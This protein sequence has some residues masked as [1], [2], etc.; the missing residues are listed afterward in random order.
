MFGKLGG[1][2]ED[3]DEDYKCSFLL[4][5]LGHLLNSIA[6]IAINV[7]GT[8]AGLNLVNVLINSLLKELRKSFQKKSLA[9]VQY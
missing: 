7:P 8:S 3:S 6:N 9:W 2:R 5:S 1:S 4:T